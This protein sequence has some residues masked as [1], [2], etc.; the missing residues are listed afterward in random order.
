MSKKIFFAAAVVFLF[1]MF[2]WVAFPV[3]SQ[4]Q[5][6]VKARL[7]IGTTPQFSAIFVAENKNYFREF[8]VDMEVKVFTSGSAAAEA[9]RAGKGEFVNAG[10]WPTTKLWERGD[11]IGIAPFVY[12]TKM[13]CITAKNG[14]SK[15]SDLK[16]KNVGVFLGSTSEYFA[17]L[18]MASEGLSFNNINVKNLRPADM[19]YALD[20][21]DIDAFVIWEPF[22][23]QSINNVSKDKVHLMSY[24]AGYFTEWQVQCVSPAFAKEN[25]KAVEGV[26]KA[27]NKANKFIKDHP[28][29]TVK[30]V[31]KRLKLD[32]SVMKELL[33]R[34]TF[35][36]S[37]TKAFRN[38]MNSLSKFM[39]DKKVLDKPIDWKTAFDSSF[40]KKVDPSL[41][42]E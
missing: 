14:L 42:E 26:L 1:C 25:P 13:S 3:T 19:V 8:G 11:A 29:E 34:M 39:L 37:Y 18:Y 27:L 28:D 33:P 16:G 9:F 32:E 40:L 10:D 35:D 22:C 12:F 2:A 6:L 5:D 21:G 15:P 31:A 38:D 30:I 17:L 7:F 24:G 4:A 41:V 23:T 36:L 20:R